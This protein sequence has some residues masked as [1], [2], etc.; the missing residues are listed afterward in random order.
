MATGHRKPF[1]QIPSFPPCQ[2]QPRYKSSPGY[3]V[4]CYGE[5]AIQRGPDSIKLAKPS[6]EKKVTDSKPKS[7]LTS[8]T[9]D[10][11]QYRNEEL[12]R[13][14]RFRETSSLKIFVIQNHEHPA[15]SFYGNG[16]ETFSVNIPM[17]VACENL[18]ELTLDT[19]IAVKL[20]R[21]MF[22]QTKKLILCKCLGT[23][24]IVLHVTL[25]P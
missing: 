10:Q 13:A 18:T 4:R 19:K 23:C 2:G 6:G 21:I 22:S 17:N 25:S 11:R 20:W 14:Q 15:S 3:S 24:I 7:H 9:E 5:C 16:K 12:S 8:N 1:V